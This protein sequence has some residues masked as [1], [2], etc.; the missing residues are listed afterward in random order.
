MGF[1]E[2]GEANQLFSSFTHWVETA[3]SYVWQLF[4]PNNHD[5]LI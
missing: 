1:T 5:D 4:L 2:A 3:I